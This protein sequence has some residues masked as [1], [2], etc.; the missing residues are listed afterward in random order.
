MRKVVDSN[1]LQSDELRDYLSKSAG[2]YVV[3][4][5]YA[6]MEAY[7]GDTL[8]TIYRSMEILADYPK[9]V[10]VLK[11]TQV[12]CGLRGRSAGLQRR[13]IDERQMKEFGEYCQHLHAAKHGNVYLQKQLLDFGREATA[14]MDRMLADAQNAP[15]AFDEI[16]KTYTD[17]ELRLLRNSSAFTEQMI[18]KLIRNVLLLAAYMFR[19]HP[20]TTKRPD[21][22]EL[23]NMF[24]FRSALCAYLLSLQ[25][26]SVGGAKK[27]KPDRIRNDMVDVNFAAYAT[28]FDGLLSADNKLMEIYLKAVSLLD[29]IFTTK[30]KQA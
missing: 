26:I 5:D 14:H 8:D 15:S 7:K 30:T 22:A 4:T 20:R 2:N 11:G 21:V 18:D 1:F 28:Y 27:V 19:D 16:A 17:N 23:P 9:Q 12:A 10:I 13:L 6:A 25:W 29:M 24:I 3:L